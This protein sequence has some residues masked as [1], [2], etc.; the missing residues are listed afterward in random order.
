[1]NGE[2]MLDALE[3]VDEELLVEAERVRQKRKKARWPFIPLAACLCLVVA[4]AMI[5][6]PWRSVTQSNSWS[7]GGETNQMEGESGSTGIYVPPLEVEVNGDAAV[8]ADML[9]FFIYQGRLYVECSRTQNGAGLVGEKLGTSDGRIDE[10]TPD[11]GYVEGSGTAWG[12]FYAVN[13]YDPTHLLCMT[14]EDGTVALYWHNNDITV[15]TGGDILDE[16][17]HMSGQVVKATMQGADVEAVASLSHLDDLN[18]WVQ[19]LCAAPA[20][21]DG[22]SPSEVLGYLYLENQD[23]VTVELAL[24]EGG[25]IRMYGLGEV[26]FQLDWMP[27]TQWKT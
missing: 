23:G 7:G 27:L 16:V 8:E 20:Q 3:Q 9:S 19:E 17:F 13:G 12:D 26:S 4:G 6:Q 10:W 14:W 1:M 2:Q 25:K 11:S 5:I 18:V 15:Q 22:D 21:W 24:C